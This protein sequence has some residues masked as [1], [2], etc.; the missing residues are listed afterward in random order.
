MM[1]ALGVLIGQWLKSL[2]K[3]TN[4]ILLIYLEKYMNTMTTEINMINANN[5][6]V[7][8][9][10]RAYLMSLLNTKEQKMFKDFVKSLGVK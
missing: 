3:Q 8:Q 7:T 9:Q 10:S 5:F 1:T 4:L 6:V 2:Q